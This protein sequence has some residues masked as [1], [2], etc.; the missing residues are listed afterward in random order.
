MPAPE[1]KQGRWYAQPRDCNGIQLLSTAMTFVTPRPV[2]GIGTV[3]GVVA[4]SAWSD[5]VM[6]RRTTTI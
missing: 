4:A 5:A 2:D 6:L 1:P 3:P